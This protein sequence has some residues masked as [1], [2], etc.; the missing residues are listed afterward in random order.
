MVQILFQLSL[1]P[2]SV[3]PPGWSQL[4]LHHY[5]WGFLR[6]L[7]DM[8]SR[9]GSDLLHLSQASIFAHLWNG[10]LATL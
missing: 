4:C 8:W 6:Q 10:F 7:L 1:P 3:A 9:L 5:S 2:W